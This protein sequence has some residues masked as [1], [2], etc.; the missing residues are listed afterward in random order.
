M[1]ADERTRLTYR[2]ESLRSI[3]AGIV[4]TA[5]GTFLLLIAVRW[6]AAGPV[7]KAC[8]AAAS[9]L[10]YVL[11]PALVTRV[12]AARTPV[13][14]AAARL[15][16]AGAA[17]FAL[18]AVLPLTWVFVIAS[19]VAIS[20][21][22][23]VHPLLTQLYQDNYPEAARGRLFSR[24]IMLR[25]VTAV[26]F[27][28]GA[29]WLLTVNIEYSRALLGIYAAALGGAGWCLARVPSQPLHLSG[30]QHPLRA[31]RHLAD[32][33][34][35]RTT[36]ISWMFMG[37]ANLMMLPMRI[38]YLANPQYR[39]GLR[40]DVIALLTSVV[41][42]VARLVMSPVWGWLFDHANFF[43]VRMTLNVGFAI[44]IVSFFTSDSMTGLVIAAITYGVSVAGGDVA[45]TLWVTKIAPPSRVAD[46]MGVH[47]FFTGVR[48]L[49][50]PV[51]GFA[52]LTRWS[53]TAMG[54]L[55]VV[56]IAIGTLVLVPDARKGLP[57]RRHVRTPSSD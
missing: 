36:L 42:N 40:A 30:E 33:R 19:M 9:G 7:A 3:A 56:L 44:G 48:G 31:F 10:G 4:E 28:L 12:E 53:M 21:S 51:V 13:A 6:F 17:A 55:S 8:V 1:L 11:A 29:G 57:E 50:A 27:G 26:V 18:A 20:C 39:L 47:T 23:A 14:A 43:V 22:A 2:Y 32:D 37:F 24:T 16:F 41:P 34:V 15:S 38:E 25:I 45:W 54:W 49:L 5:S 52:L 35:F 46:Y